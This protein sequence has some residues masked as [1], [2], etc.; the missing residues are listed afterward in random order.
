MTELPTTNKTPSAGVQLQGLEAA[1][2]PSVSMVA[3]IK[4][5]SRKDSLLNNCVHSASHCSLCK[6]D[7]QRQ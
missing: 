6:Q 4:S 1:T 5:L 2:G 7:I 3:K